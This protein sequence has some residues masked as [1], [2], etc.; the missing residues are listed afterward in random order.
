MTHRWDLHSFCLLARRRSVFRRDSDRSRTFKGH[1]QNIGQHSHSLIRGDGR[2]SLACLCRG[3]LVHHQGC[4]AGPGREA[5]Q[6]LEPASNRRTDGLLGIRRRSCHR[7][8]RY[9]ATVSHRC[10]ACPRVSPSIIRRRPA[11]ADT[12]RYNRACRVRSIE[13][14]TNARACQVELKVEASVGEKASLHRC[15]CLWFVS[16]QLDD[17]PRVKEPLIARKP[18]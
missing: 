2:V 14:W 3:R 15:S 5:G 6:E 17:T 13:R 7:S 12:D 16:E 11:S 9:N 8:S 10:P 18:D 1:E 4:N